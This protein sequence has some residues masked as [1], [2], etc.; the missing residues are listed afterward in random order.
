MD[1]KQLEAVAS[2]LTAA[3]A[4]F[5]KDKDFHTT[6]ETFTLA[7]LQNKADM[8]KSAHLIGDQAMRC[9]FNNQGQWVCSQPH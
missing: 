6:I 8:P 2:V 4:D 3:L 9:H 7:Q 1:N 5:L